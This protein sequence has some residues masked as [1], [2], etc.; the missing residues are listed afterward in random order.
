MLTEN[1]LKASVGKYGPQNKQCHNTVPDQKVIQN[2]LNAIPV[3]HGGADGKLMGSI[4]Q[5]GVVDEELHKAILK[6]QKA[7][8]REG[9][10]VDGHVDPHEK[11]IRLMVRLAKDELDP[12]CDF[13]VRLHFRSLGSPKVP[14]MI[15]LNNAQRVYGPNGISVVMASGQSLL[16]SGGDTLT[17]DTVDM[18]CQW[19]FISGEQE[20]VQNLGGFQGVG[21]TDVLVYYVNNIRQPDGSAL[22]GC[23]GHAPG[24]AALIVSAIGSPWTLAHELGHVLLGSKF[25]PVHSTDSTNVMFSPSASITAN[26]PNFTAAQLTAIK[27]SALCVSC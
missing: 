21:P 27:A 5:W 4:R 8:A 12:A 22:A 18:Q 13:R 14:E 23:A 2:L 19:D 26:P 9:L 16:L 1:D 17:L 15:A 11:T 10:S 25:I 7:H 3:E 6:F 20:I 24:R